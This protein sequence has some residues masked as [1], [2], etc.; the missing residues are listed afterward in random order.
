MIN[1]SMGFD[2]DFIT[3]FKIFWLFEYIMYESFNN[4][5]YVL[6]IIKCFIEHIIFRSG[7]KR[8]LLLFVI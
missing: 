4:R 1:F 2:L 6:F 7:Q 5:R 8:I 3:N